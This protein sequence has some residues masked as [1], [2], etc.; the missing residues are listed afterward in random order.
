MGNKIEINSGNNLGSR[1][2]KN[3]GSMGALAAGVTT[4]TAAGVA[5]V[6]VG[7]ADAAT[8]WLQQGQHYSI[9][10]SNRA[11]APFAKWAKGA[12]APQALS[13]ITVAKVTQ[14]AAAGM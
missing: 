7:E 10:G 1:G 14:T 2:S 8:R 11:A 9:R 12:A 13:L 5:T 4:A 3:R 6:W